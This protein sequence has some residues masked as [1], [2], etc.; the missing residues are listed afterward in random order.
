MSGIAGIYNRDGRP[1][2]AA[3][4]RRMTGAMAH[5]GPDGAEHW[6]RGAVA[7]GHCMLHTTP[8][9]LLEQQPLTDE[10]GELCLT[11]D[12]RLD[13]R[14][15]LRQALEA[16]GLRLRSETDAELV[17]RAYECW[18]EECPARIL[19]DFAFAIWD[20][21]RRQLFCAR[22]ILGLKP[23][24]Y[25]FDGRR[26][27]FGSELRQLFED[28]AIARQPNEGMIG[29][30]LA[31]AVTDPEQTLFQG[32][33]RLS[34]AHFLAIQSDKVRKARY[35]DPDPRREIR[36]SSDEE[37]AE[38]FRELFQ[39]AVR[40]RLRSH[41]PVA[42]YL[43]GGLD[44]SSVVSMAQ[45]LHQREGPACH[46][47]ETFSLVF[48]GMWCD[49][50]EYIDD[51]VGM[52]KLTSNRRRPRRVD[53]PY[54]ANSIRRSYDCADLPGLAMLDSLK[55]LA[56]QKGMRVL[57]NGFGGDEW[58]TGSFYH[59]ADLL[60][61]GRI[62][63]LLQQIRSDREYYSSALAAVVFP[64]Q[65]LFRLGVLPLIPGGALRAAKW[66]LGRDGFPIWIDPGFAKRIRLAERLR[67]R[68]PAPKFSSIAQREV[69]RLGTDIRQSQAYE[70]E[71]SLAS[72][73]HL[74]QRSPFL[75]RRIVE[76]GLAL[77][78]DQ[79]WRREQTK[80]VLRQALRTH[81]PDA[82][83]GRLTKA[84]FSPIVA[85]A[86]VP[87]GDGLV[88]SLAVEQRGWVDGAQI[89]AMYGRLKQLHE[90]GNTGSSPLIGPLFMVFGMELW[91]RTIF[92]D[93]TFSPE[94]EAFPME[95]FAAPALR[96]AG[97]IHRQYIN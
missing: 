84:E 65:A 38:H 51:V 40:C 4:L 95:H 39:E 25:Y 49:E 61:R 68:A 88:G 2:D 36:H 1:A 78:Q 20:G 77:P 83:R 13:N 63:M 8:E 33:L 48:P 5:R 71:E 32:I 57:L 34:P 30:Y 96:D 43:S 10:S 80:F 72:G 92:M 79:L 44:S 86:L 50:S 55:S 74:E 46:G 75:D 58:L 27:L 66:M 89:R 62:R 28:A 52:W 16:K 64:K 15:E 11:M 14:A 91:F 60:R 6:V 45:S 26:F 94:E 56:R 87:A 76:F 17:L 81:L 37:Y 23:F 67:W 9:S 97:P 18:G 82:V 93:A 29:E 31:N 69:Y 24:Y 90:Q 3:L 41:K 7:L 22:D 70:M 12:G 21:R 59:Y 53:F 85:G 54:Y 19:G 73:F 42:A 47:L 35:W